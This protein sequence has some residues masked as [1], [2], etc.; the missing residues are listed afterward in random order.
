MNFFPK[1]L[2]SVLDPVNHQNASVVRKPKRRR[3]NGGHEELEGYDPDAL[4]TQTSTGGGAEL[5]EGVKKR[6]DAFGPEETQE[7]ETQDPDAEPE[8]EDDDF[9]E[10]ELEGGDD[11]DAE[12][13]FN[14]GGDDM[15]G[16]DD[17]NGDGG[18]YY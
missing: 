4:I 16:G 14:D 8:P 5:S 18:D 1:E 10:P 15:D 2:W 13:Y 3:V 9:G 7:E 17:A 12:A 6:I 11:Y